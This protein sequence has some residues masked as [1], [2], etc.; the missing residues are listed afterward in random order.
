NVSCNGG[1]DGS[2]TV[3][4]SGGT[5]PYAY[6]LNGGPYQASPTFGGLSAGSYTIT[7][8]DAN[9]CTAVQNV[10][11]TEPAALAF[12][13][14]L[15][16]PV[17]C[18]GEM[19]GSITVT[20]TGGTPPYQY[21][22]N[23]GAL[24]NSPTFSGLAAGTYTITVQD[25]NGCTATSSVTVTEPPV[26]TFTFSVTNAL[27]HGENGTI[28]FQPSGGVGGYEY[29][30]NGVYG[31]NPAVSLPAGTYTLTVRD[32][33][34]CVTTPQTATITQPTALLGSVSNLV[35]ATC[36]ES[37]DASV[38]LTAT[39][40]TPSPAGYTF[41][42]SSHPQYSGAS[43]TGLAPGDYTVVVQD[44][45]GCTDT[46]RFSIP[47]RSY[48]D[49][50]I[51]PVQVQGCVPL[52]VSWV[53]FPAGIGPYT[54][55]WTLGDGTVATDSVVQHV[56]PVQGSY[57]VTLVI[58]NADG[59]ADTATATANAFFVP[60]PAYSIE[61]DTSEDRVVGTVFTLT[62]ITQNAQQVWWEIPG[63]GR[64]EGT[65]WQVRF[66][67]P[68][69]YCFTLWARNG[70][71]VDSTRGCIRVKDPYLYLPNAFS[72]NG[73]GVNDLFE[74]KTFGLKE[75]RVRIYDRWGLLIFD[76]Q[77]DMS[78]HWD[79][80]YQGRPV[81]EDAYTVVIEGKLPPTDKPFKRTTTATVVR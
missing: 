34:G 41:T 71:C 74:I 56:Y 48:V 77:G 23:G 35:P 13:A 22:L 65:P 76:N 69:E 27:C 5:P 3:S 64:H 19:N 73:D 17:R 45:N 70:S 43:V 38:T 46:I 54:Y 18:N 59:C 36:R 80:T 47:Y 14:P 63:Y 33:N 30:V 1:S 49:A 9:G 81:P 58:R 79:G 52:V 75:P 55:Q 57:G 26:L 2:V 28:T 61:P 21:S 11:V 60:T 25:V 10:V 31:T 44:G 39:G 7:V 40:G 42:W 78:R 15:I 51:Q 37:A 16:T 24:Q 8:R 67:K 50:A 12:G 68:G 62:S 20:V 29:G 72:P 6:S 32:A 53:A 4:V 66:D